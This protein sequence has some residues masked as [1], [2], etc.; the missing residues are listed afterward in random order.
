MSTVLDRLRDQRPNASTEALLEA[1]SSLELLLIP[2]PDKNVASVLERFGRH[3]WNPEL[4][5]PK[6]PNADLMRMAQ[7]SDPFGRVLES[8]LK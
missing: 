5:R 6:R 1:A 7:S 8:L 4:N 3:L 2:V